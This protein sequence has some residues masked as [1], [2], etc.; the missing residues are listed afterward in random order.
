MIRI[1]PAGRLVTRAEVARMMVA[2]C[3]PAFDLVT[4]MTLP[5][6]GGARLPRF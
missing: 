6:D 2:L 3:S 4:G 1:T 5:M